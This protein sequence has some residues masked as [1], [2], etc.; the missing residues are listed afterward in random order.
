MHFP[1][2]SCLDVC[3][4]IPLLLAMTTHVSTLCVEKPR[5]LK[6]FKSQGMVVCAVEVLEEGKVRVGHDIA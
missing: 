1:P 2:L 4:A 3:D 5:N 6:G